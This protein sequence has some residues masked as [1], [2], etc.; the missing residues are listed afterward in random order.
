MGR[1]ANPREY[2]SW[3]AMKNRCIRGKDPSYHL[4]GARGIRV[5][6][7]WMDS[8]SNFLSDLGPR[9][10]GTTL[11]RIDGNKNYE[12]GNCR[13][14]T[15]IEQSVNRRTTRFFVV[16]GEVLCLKHCAKKYGMAPI[17]LRKRLEMGLSIEEALAF[18]KWQKLNRN[19]NR[20]L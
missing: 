13:W 1:T 10:L 5:C 12:P 15:R 11:D 6:E 17:T 16:N 3:C 4:Y 18:P 20:T 9:P 19:T 2:S 8:F 7:R 14:A